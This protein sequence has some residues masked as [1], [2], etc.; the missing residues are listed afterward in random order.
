MDI[1]IYPVL[2]V[3]TLVACVVSARVLWARRRRKRV[4]RA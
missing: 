3:V 2:L 4:E 1:F